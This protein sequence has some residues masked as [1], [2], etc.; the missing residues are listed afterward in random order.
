MKKLLSVFIFLVAFTFTLSISQAVDIWPFGK[1][2][3]SVAPA[4][5]ADKASNSV[6]VVVDQAPPSRGE[7][8]T[9]SFSGVVTKVSPS[10]VNVLTTKQVTVQQGNQ[11]IMMDPF[12]RRFFGDQFKE[13]PQ[14]APQ[15]RT[16]KEQGLGSGVIMSKDGY[17]ITNNHVIEGMDEIVVG[18]ANADDGKT[19]PAK[20]IGKD[21]RTDIAILK[22]EG[23]DFQAAT[24]G[25][26]DKIEVG[27]VVLA[28]GNPFGVGQTVTMGIIS[29]LS[30]A[31]PI[32]NEISYQDFIQTDASIN[33]GNSGGALVDSD[34][35]VIGINTAI[36]SR[37]GGNQGIGFAVPINLARSVMTSILEN[38]R[39]IRGFLGVVIQPI[40]PE[41]AKAFKLTTEQ[42]ALVSQV[43]PGEAGDK[44][45]LKNGDVITEFNGV[46]TKG[47]KELRMLVGQTPPKKPIKV[48]Y[49]REGREKETTVTLSELSPEKEELAMNNPIGTD[50]KELFKGVDLS[51]VTPIIRQQL[52]LPDTIKGAVVTNLDQNAQAYEDGLR[53]GDVIIELNQKS[54]SSLDELTKA[55]Q[56]NKEPSY[57]LRV[58]TNGAIRYLVLKK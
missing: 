25:D 32:F 22:I 53:Q 50:S 46:K 31:L 3:E 51:E 54:V 41:L 8:L 15:E 26:S 16:R 37:T 45:G 11:Q 23:T 33:P 19:Y 2:E 48:K 39:V 1:K 18:L 52:K 38:G 57:L 47:V 43:T 4:P 12:F 42:G 7:K 36:L 5:T 29:A 21:P 20:I 30:R 40:T 6:K 24:L 56:A 55:V 58:W 49:L 14:M 13:M 34:G 28:V 9:T 27:D 35:R 17:V 44:A 10:V